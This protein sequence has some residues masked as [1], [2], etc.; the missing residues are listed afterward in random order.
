MLMKA[1]RNIQHTMDTEPSYQYFNTSNDTPSNSIV[2]HRCQAKTETAEKC[3]F[4]ENMTCSD[5]L[6]SCVS[7]QSLYCSVCC[8]LDY[9]LSITQAFCLSCKQTL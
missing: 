1:Q 4:C 7:C 9:S 8:I 3:N 6:Q 5:C 2:C